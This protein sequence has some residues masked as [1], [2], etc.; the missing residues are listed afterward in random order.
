[1]SLWKMAFEKGTM[2]NHCGLDNPLASTNCNEF[3]NFPQPSKHAHEEK[4]EFP[5]SPDG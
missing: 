1:M 3:F 4:L 5:P 2:E